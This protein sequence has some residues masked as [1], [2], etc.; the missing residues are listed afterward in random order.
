MASSLT[1]VYHL[2]LPFCVMDLAITININVFFHFIAIYKMYIN[3]KQLQKL[4]WICCLS[5]K[6]TSIM[7]LFLLYLYCLWHNHPLMIHYQTHAH[8][9]NIYLSMLL[10]LLLCLVQSFFSIKMGLRWWMWQWAWPWHSRRPNILEARLG[11][12]ETVSCSFTKLVSC[13]ST[14]FIMGLGGGEFPAFVHTLPWLMRVIM[15]AE[16]LKH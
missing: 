8:I 13:S 11:T 9:R 15:L 16:W 7:F 4:F 10:L 6:S 2:L 5:L 14:H 12:E 3:I 1:V